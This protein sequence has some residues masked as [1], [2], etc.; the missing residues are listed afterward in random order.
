MRY[1]IKGHNPVILIFSLI[2]LFILIRQWQSGSWHSMM[3]MSD[4]M[5]A[6]FLIFGTFK[7]I[8]L[9]GFVAMYKKYNLVAEYLT[10]YAYAFPFLQVGIGIAYLIHVYALT[11]NFINFII[12][13][14]GFI[15]ILIKIIKKEI[16]PCACLG[17]LFRHYLSLMSLFENALMVAM[18][19][20]MVLYHYYHISM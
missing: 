4:F 15:S 3:A 19:L 7:I 9:R 5:G 13:T 12:M 14:I 16:I 2:T 18:A 17:T 6:Y 8:D 11:S 10:L 1:G 20:A